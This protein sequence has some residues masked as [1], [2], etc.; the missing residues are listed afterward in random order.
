MDTDT[1]PEPPRCDCG[2]PAIAGNLC[3]ECLPTCSH[4]DLIARL[5]AFARNCVEHGDMTP[6]AERMLH[7]ILGISR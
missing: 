2:L 3:I 6:T 5:Q 7:S 4:G 1:V